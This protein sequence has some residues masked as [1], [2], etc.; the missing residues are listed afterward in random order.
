MRAG[1]DAHVVFTN[2][3]YRT[4][5]WLGVLLLEMGAVGFVIGSTIFGINLLVTCAY[6]RMN[7]N[8][9]FS[10]FRMNR[11]NNFIR[12]RIC[13]DKIDVF[14]VGLE[15]V[16]KRSSWKLN[17]RRGEGN[18]DEPVYVP[19]EPLQPHLIEKFTVELKKW[20]W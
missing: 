2:D 6:F 18:P 13:G 19:S 20:A 16:P 12:L 9:A 17:P 1:N 14:A 5:E 11:Y 8:D 10:A 7:H 15:R 3:W 4:W